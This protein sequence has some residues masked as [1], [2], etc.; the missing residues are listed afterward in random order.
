MQHQKNSH[1]SQTARRPFLWSTRAGDCDSNAS[2]L[3][4][5]VCEENNILSEKRQT[6]ESKWCQVIK[7]RSQ[8]DV[9][10]TFVGS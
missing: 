4:S 6:H 1:S 9:T 8:F 2:V 10:E 5:T 3:L 7:M